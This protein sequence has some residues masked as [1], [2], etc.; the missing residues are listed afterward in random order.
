M[1]LNSDSRNKELI[2]INLIRNKKSLSDIQ[3]DRLLSRLKNDNDKKEYIDNYSYLI[4]AMEKHYN[5]ASS[6]RLE[7]FVKNNL[8]QMNKT[9]GEIK[10][11]TY[12]QGVFKY[13]NDF[14]YDIKDN[15]IDN[16]ELKFKEH[17]EGQFLNN[18]DKLYS[19]KKISKVMYLDYMNK[20]KEKVFI[21]FT[22]PNKDFHKYNKWGKLT[23]T[24]TNNQTLEENI[25]SG[26]KY[27]NE[28]HR[29]YYHTLKYKVKRYCKK[30]NIK[31]TAVMNID[32]IK[33]LEPH[34]SLDGHLHSLFYLDNEFLDIAEQVY[35][36]TIKHFKLKQ[37]K[38]EIL[39]NAKGSTYLTKYLLKTTR[40]ENLFYNHYKRYFSN[41]RFFSSSNF[42]HTTQEKIELVYKYL[43]KNNPK[44]LQRY[45][46]SKKPI[47]LHIENL[48]KKKVFKF[49]EVENISYTVDNKKIDKEFKKTLKNFDNWSKIH[50]DN[51]DPLKNKWL[52]N[53]TSKEKQEKLKWLDKVKDKYIQKFK[54]KVIQN[55]SEYIITSKSK[56][57]QKIY[58]KNELVLDKTEWEFMILDSSYFEELKLNPFETPE[59]EEKLF[60]L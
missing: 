38:Y 25:S 46:A 57:I 16:K 7:Y 54:S 44:L 2:Q 39:E 31:A 49:E 33:M 60:N 30:N 41:V 13:Y 27:L 37:T 40:D 36:M 21:T 50:Y 32:F 4:N 1:Y 12:N 3:V 34:K 47:Y 10:D 58:Y 6:K 28:I 56:S 29:Y 48:I 18:A 42:R 45:K 11:Y 24:Y 53:M 43:S 19:I 5:N 23:K 20:D 26:L 51:L 9:T 52:Y 15:N 17:V 55:L 22:L 35:N 14:Y 8:M 59:V